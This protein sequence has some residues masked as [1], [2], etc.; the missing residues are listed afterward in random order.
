MTTPP[1]ATA[2]GELAALLRAR[3]EAL[4][5]TDVGLA[6]R[7]SPTRTPGLRR[8]EVAALAGVSVDYLI[9]L[10]QGRD[11]RPSAQVV[12]ALAAALQLDEH[13]SGYLFTLAG[14]RLPERPGAPVV[15]DGLRHLVA[16]FA[17]APAMVLN[18]RLDILVWNEPMAGLLLDFDRRPA[19]ERNIMRMCF[20]DERF[21]GFYPDVGVVRGAVADLRA[22]WVTHAADPELAQLIT[23]LEHGS[24]QFLAHWRSRDV[25]VAASGTKAM[26]HP[27]AGEL[28]VTFE[29]LAPLGDPHLRLLVYRPADEPSRQALDRITAARAG[30]PTHRLRAL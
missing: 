27:V 16:D 18:H 1:S 2:R 20:L 3:R 13:Q 24:E 8:E 12:E 6:P 17:P 29:A 15:S 7:V 19:R 4:L 23:E 14:H 11:V 5:T 10:E 22:A 25:T 28:S 9:R 21:Q 26:H 30:D